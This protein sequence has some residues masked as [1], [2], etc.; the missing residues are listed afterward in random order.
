MTRNFPCCRHRRRGAKNLGGLQVFC[1]NEQQGVNISVL[2]AWVKIYHINIL[3]SSSFKEKHSRFL[4][5]KK[6]CLFQL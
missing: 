3:L 4:K 1:P 2:A 5:L 6:H